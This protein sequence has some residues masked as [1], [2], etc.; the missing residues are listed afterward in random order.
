MASQRELAEGFLALHYQDRPL[1]LPNPWDEG[2]ARLLAYLG[3]TALGT[4]SSGFAAASGLPDGSASRDDALAHAAVIASATALPVS[5]DLEGGFGSDPRAVGETYRRA[6]ATGLA[7]ASIEDFDRDANDIYPTGLASERVVAAAEACHSGEIRLVLTA[8]AEN[9][10]RGRT[11]LADTITRLQA[12]QE[13]G[14]DVLYAPG[15]TDLTDIRSVV[16]SVNRPVNVL[17]RPN[18]P[19]VAELASV[20][21]ARVSVGG[22]FAFAALGAM[23]NAARELLEHGTYS[24]YAQTRV[25]GAAV[26]DAFG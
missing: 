25:G 8:R 23:V 7:G 26:R 17:A 1:L 2:S 5:A 18:G 12:Y 3:F 10:F 13:A 14:A 4:T 6:R 9:F 22:G 11:D 20:G 15:L 21:V 24:W 16:E 19:S